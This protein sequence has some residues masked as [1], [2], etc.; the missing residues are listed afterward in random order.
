MDS[1]PLYFSDPDK[2]RKPAT[3]AA[4]RYVIVFSAVMNFQLVIRFAAA[5]C[6]GDKID[7]IVYAVFDISCLQSS[8]AAIIGNGAVCIA[9][10]TFRHDNTS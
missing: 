9:D 1:P 8:Q 10:F 5:P 3:T 7:E 6:S 4:Q 2:V